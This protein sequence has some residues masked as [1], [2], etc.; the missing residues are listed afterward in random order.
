VPTSPG[1]TPKNPNSFIS[2][3]AVGAREK[4]IGACFFR[5]KRHFPGRFSLKLCYNPS[6]QLQTGGWLKSCRV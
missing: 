6:A 3:T 4:T 2:N 5:E 1:F